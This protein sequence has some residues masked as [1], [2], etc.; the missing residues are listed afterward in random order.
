M[1]Y[2]PYQVKLF[3]GDPIEIRLLP[4]GRSV[5]PVCGAITTGEPPYSQGE[6]DSSG[7]LKNDPPKDKLW[8]T[9]SMDICPQCHTQYGYS[10]FLED[11]PGMTQSQVWAKLRREWL[12]RVNWKPAALTQLA[13]N[14]DI[15]IVQLQKTRATIAGDR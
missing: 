11:F 10:D 8:A 15:D 9:G 4:D 14:L 6:F 12:D 5:C 13:E 2:T 1:Q 3:N 7:K